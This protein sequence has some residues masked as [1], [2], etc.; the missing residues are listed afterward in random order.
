MFCCRR[1]SGSRRTGFRLSTLV[2]SPLPRV[3]ERLEET[4]DATEVV[5]RGSM[6]VEQSYPFIELALR[7]GMVMEARARV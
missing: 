3:C 5:T 4:S 7:S 6:M 2:L 1:F